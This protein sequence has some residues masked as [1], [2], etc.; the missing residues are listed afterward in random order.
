MPLPPIYVIDFEGNNQYGIMEWGAACVYQ[1]SIV[2]FRCG[3][4]APNYQV[5]HHCM[6]HSR[7]DDYIGD[8]F[9]LYLP[10]FISCRQIGIFCSHGASVDQQLLC[11]YQSTPGMVPTFNN[12]DGSNGLFAFGAQRMW[13]NDALINN[14]CAPPGEQA[15]QYKHTSDDFCAAEWGPWIDTYRLSKKYFH[16]P[17]KRTVRQLI[18]T[19]QL[20]S[21][22]ENICK[23]FQLKKHDMHFHRA[24]YDAISTAAI[25]K[26]MIHVLSIDD[27]S[28]L[29]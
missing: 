13:F 28:M 10:L 25:L 2:D 3:K 4:C 22:V 14:S 9:F 19:F 11:M 7:F 15:E 12:Y 27:L 16:I 6:Q 29:I 1:H 26:F 8:D 18:D 20:Q 24:G 5:M 21:E 23:Y 17:G